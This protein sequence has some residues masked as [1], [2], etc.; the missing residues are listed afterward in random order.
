MPTKRKT[1]KSQ[2]VEPGFGVKDYLNTLEH[3]LK[4]AVCNLRDMI[5]AIDPRIKEEVKWNAPSFRIKEHFATFRLQ[6]AP[7]CQLVLHTGSKVRKSGT[8]IEIP[9][10]DG[11]LEWASP[12]RCIV[13][14]A[15]TADAKAKRAALQRILKAWIKQADVA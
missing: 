7:I 4:A 15:S 12:D 14:F 11:F 13:T 3:P 6:P 2:R 1:P 10:P 8:Q 9:D 5:L